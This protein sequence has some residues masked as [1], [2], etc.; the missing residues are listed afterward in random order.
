MFYYLAAFEHP[1][2]DATIETLGYYIVDKDPKPMKGQ[3]SPQLISFIMSM[4]EKN[5]NNRPTIFDIHLKI[6]SKNETKI[7]NKVS[8]HN[9]R[10]LMSIKDVLKREAEI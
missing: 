10:T 8:I 7:N 3:Y 9:I 1:F 4:L 2:K 5:P 6:R